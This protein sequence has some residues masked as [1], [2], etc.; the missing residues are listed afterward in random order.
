MIRLLKVLKSLSVGVVEN[1]VK[2]KAFY[3]KIIG[4]GPAVCSPSSVR[5]RYVTRA[6][7]PQTKSQLAKGS[8]PL[9]KALAKWILLVPSTQAYVTSTNV[10]CYERTSVGQRLL[11]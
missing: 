4:P 1:R 11:L 8:T 6:V 7:M 5:I 2:T 9:K 3:V 10:S